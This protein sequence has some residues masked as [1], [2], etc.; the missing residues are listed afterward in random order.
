MIDDYI[1][2]L[3]TLM[4]LS[5]IEELADWD[6]QS[7]PTPKHQRGKRVHTFVDENGKVSPSPLCNLRRMQSSRALARLR[8]SEIITFLAAM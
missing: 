3:K 6:G 8:D 5:Q 1:V 2:G 7:P 4:Y